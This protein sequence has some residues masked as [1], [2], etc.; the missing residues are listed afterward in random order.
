VM[1]I[2]NASLKGLLVIS[3]I[4]VLL[5]LTKKTSP[6]TL[7]FVWFLSIAGFILL[8][9]LT[10]L[11]SSIPFGSIRIPENPGT[12]YQ[13]ISS[14]AAINQNFN[15]DIP[16]V[17]SAAASGSKTFYWTIFF[18]IWFAGAAALLLR[19]LIGS[20]R[21]SKIVN[22]GY[23]A[24]EKNLL[25]LLRSLQVRSRVKSPLHILFSPQTASPFTTGVFK[26]VIVLPEYMNK[27]TAAEL[28]PVLLHELHHIRRKDY[29]TQTAAMGICSLF[30]FVPPLWMALRKLYMEQEKACDAEV[31]RNGVT[32]RHYINQMLKIA[33]SFLR[34]AAS[35]GLFMIN[36]RK[37]LFETR[38]I[39]ILEKKGTIM[40]KRTLILIA[41]GFTLVLS[42]LA[43]CIATHKAVS[44][45]EFLTSWSGT[46]VNRDVEGS[47]MVPQK[48]VAYPDGGYDIFVYATAA[49]NF[50][51]HE[52]ELIEQWTD[53]KG[54]LWFKA[55]GFC[56]KKGIDGYMFGKISGAGNI[57][58]FQ[59]NTTNEPINRLEPDS[60]Y[61]HYC[62]YYR[63]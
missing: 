23:A 22:H 62:K 50:C 45:E 7:H 63:E 42:V 44:E 49:I 36:G 31:V 54:D 52:I 6:Q 4:Y 28:E 9:A 19:T 59:F 60:I 16:I 1:V 34:P 30:W 13:T 41:V 58:E 48:I 38:I 24:K 8:P 35:P 10:F 27:W 37:K 51:H 18:F 53:A 39:N 40:K 33:C 57:L 20:A 25:S 11:T 29:I 5:S 15:G 55:N 3:C 61:S 26:P 14:V 32:P 12:V 21:A 56:R 17:S 46:W 47:V 2:L 43:G